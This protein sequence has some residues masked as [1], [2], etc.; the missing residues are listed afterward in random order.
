MTW[1]PAEPK[2]GPSVNCDRTKVCNPTYNCLSC[3]GL[4]IS[5]QN[6]RLLRYFIS[7]PTFMSSSLFRLGPQFVEGDLEDTV[8][9]A[10]IRLNK[11][12]LSRGLHGRPRVE[13]ERDVLERFQGRTPYLRPLLDKRIE[14]C[15]KMCVGSIGDAT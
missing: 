1:F 15:L 5:S 2:F 13:N 3:L 4:N 11:L 12:L 7:S 8:W 10:K 6:F 9:L 14:A